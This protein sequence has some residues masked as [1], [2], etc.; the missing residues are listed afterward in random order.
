[1]RLLSWSPSYKRAYRRYI[2]R[3]P[4]ERQRIEQTLRRLAQDPFM[5]ELDTHKLKGTLAGLWACSAAFDC[6]IVFDLLEDGVILQVDMGTH[7]E[8]Y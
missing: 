3:H 2:Q 6:R 8:V 4:N 1:M 7:D 5:P